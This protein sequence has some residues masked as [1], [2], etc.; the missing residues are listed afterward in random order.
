M[1]FHEL[2]HVAASRQEAVM[3][4]TK[5]QRYNLDLPAAK[6]EE[7]SKPRSE[8]VQRLIQEKEQEKLEKERQ[9]QRKERKEREERDRKEKE[10]R[11][12]NQFRIP[13]KKPEL[14]VDKKQLINSLFDDDDDDGDE[15]LEHKVETDTAKINGF[16]TTK[17]TSDHSSSSRSNN[18]SSSSNS[19]SSEKDSKRHS[20][21][22]SSH[23]SSSEDRKKSHSSSKENH[24]S[25]KSSSSSSSKHSN[26]VSSSSLSSTSSSKH[27]SH[28][29]SSKLSKDFS[30]TASSSHHKSE[31]EP[32][33]PESLKADTSHNNPIPLNKN[34]LNPVQER[35]AESPYLTEKAKIL[36]RLQAIK[37]RTKAAIAMEN[38]GK[39]K[40]IRGV[41]TQR[42]SKS[43]EQNEKAKS[44]EIVKDNISSDE[45]DI[46]DG[47]SALDIMLSE[48][49]AKLEKEKIARLAKQAWE[50]ATK[51]NDEVPKDENRK[52]KEHRHK[53][54]K[55][56]YFEK[57]DKLSSHKEK[58]DG[59]VSPYSS[60]KQQ[61]SKPKKPVIVKHA[62]NAPPPM[63]FQDIL[64]IAEKKSKEPVKP[65]ALFNI[66][67]KKKDEEKRPMT[68][69]EKDRMERR[70]TKEYQDWLKF[71]GKQPKDNRRDSISDDEVEEE[72][73]PAPH[74][75]SK[76]PSRPDNR[77]Q[78][79]L[80]GSSSTNITTSTNHRPHK[81]SAANNHKRPTHTSNIPVNENLLVC[82][83]GD[84]DE[85][86]ESADD[87]GTMQANPFDR[88]MKQVHKK[89]QAPQESVKPSKRMRID[90]E[91]E[92][93]DSDMDDFIDDGDDGAFDVSKEIQS[94][95]G[96]DRSRF[97]NER[98]DDLSDMEANFSTVMAEEKRSAKIGHM[99]DL[100]D[101]RREEEELR[102]KAALKKK[103]RRAK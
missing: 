51:S 1:D 28:H 103:M 16:D 57:R 6:R 81:S 73:R 65:A 18:S 71:G 58:R 40:R 11:K 39:G 53:S 93:E 3:K 33:K 2:M 79:T 87:V 38:E 13:K 15:S 48:R 34:H 75:G 77:S 7:K 37:E 26:G 27:K 45:E 54:D 5:K 82:G 60:S 100:E 43:E 76:L 50:R 20:S 86:S 98:E 46:N 30:K 91:E 49:N 84:D 64:A 17:T 35:H 95:F 67:K 80:A 92:E 68:Q 55:N 32:P 44:A 78:S 36:A 56:R 59:K 72:K 29:S 85:D 9:R 62:H 69:E 24:S 52:H 8:T 88:I 21:S 99:E 14:A 83:P 96:Y 19:K 66:P 12:R 63:N 10:E 90:S 4:Q 94:L 42:K 97:K 25:S 70:K 31:K 89:R 102:R 41:K 47:P 101:M 22:H 74:Q 61:A 23:K